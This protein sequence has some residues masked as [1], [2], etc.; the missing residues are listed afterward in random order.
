MCSSAD[1]LLTDAIVAA[2]AF[3]PEATPLPT[4]CAHITAHARLLGALETVAA[5]VLVAH[6]SQGGAH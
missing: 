4:K 3:V 6:F 5:L 1:T 2:P